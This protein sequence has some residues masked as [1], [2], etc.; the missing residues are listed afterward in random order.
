MQFASEL[1]TSAESAKDLMKHFT[2]VY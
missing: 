2:E 1:R